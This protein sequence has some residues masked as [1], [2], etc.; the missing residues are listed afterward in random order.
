MDVT[1]CRL[2]DK[3]RRFEGACCFHLEGRFYSNLIY[4]PQINRLGKLHIFR[5][6]SVTK[7]FR[8]Q[9]VALVFVLLKKFA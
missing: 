8:Y 4:I 7:N 3:Q 9:E 1:P 2:A 5:K 6:Y